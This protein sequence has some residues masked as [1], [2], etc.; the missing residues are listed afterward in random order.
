MFY[1]FGCRL[2]Q[3][4]QLKLAAT[5]RRRMRRCTGMKW[6]CCILVDVRR[7]ERDFVGERER[8]AW[9]SWPTWLVLMPNRFKFASIMVQLVGKLSA[10]IL[11]PIFNLNWF[12]MNE[13]WLRAYVW[14]NEEWV[15]LC[16]NKKASW[17]IVRSDY[18][19]TNAPFNAC[20]R[21]FYHRKQ[22]LNYRLNN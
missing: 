16:R 11:L 15:W 8:Y 22:T 9:D 19:C 2:Y 10:I 21:L 7:H 17:L 6:W 13:S 18:R 1:V 5:N 12:W 20:I 3:C 14:V 4:I